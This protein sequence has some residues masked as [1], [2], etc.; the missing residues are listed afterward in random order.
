MKNGIFVTDCE[1]PIS[2]NDNAFELSSE[3]ISDGERLFTQL[4]RYDDVQAEIIKR[5]GYNA[6][7]TLKLIVPFL[8]AYGVTNREI[9]E[10]SAK[11]I[12]VMPGA[13]E[14]LQALR[15]HMP[16]FIVST[17]YEQYIQV[18]CEAL[19]FPF[20]NTY[21]TKL[22]IDSFP[23]NEQEQRKIK[24]LAHEICSMPSIEVPQGA[25][26]VHDLAEQSSQSVA[27]ISE[28]LWNEIPR[29]RLGRKFSSL[30]PMGGTQKARAVTSIAS[31]AGSSLDRVMY[32]GDSITDVEC[33]RLIKKSRGVTISFNGNAY[34][35]NGAEIA[36]LSHNSLP[37]TIL[38]LI[39]TEFGRDST[40]KLVHQMEQDGIRKA[41]EESNL[42]PVLK[43][44]IRELSS[45]H[46]PQVRLITRKN[47]REI[48]DSSCLF[49]RLV[50][51]A[52]IGNLG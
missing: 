5:E 50:R 49:R 32:V 22:D 15:E 41:V 16:S 46:L 13:K 10:F 8:K 2:K 6:G 52:K 30:N 33:L 48:V 43:H 14:T 21:H 44:R 37:I 31:D 23:M 39:F 1:G 12:L 24:Q 20:E 35:V 4:S 11:S 3:F 45:K 42:D 34:A 51:G 26:S 19:E 17:S 9:T 36:V 7:D 27:R 18:L 38:G 28:I 47:I 25:K 40:L 29:M